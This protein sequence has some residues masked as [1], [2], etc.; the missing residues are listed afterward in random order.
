MKANKMLLSSGSEFPAIITY[1][2]SC[3]GNNAGPV[4]PKKVGTL[5]EHT[6]PA[7]S[8]PIILEALLSLA[9]AGRLEGQ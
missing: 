5:R 1:V 7:S 2:R 6:N 9:V 8:Q 3:W 4:T